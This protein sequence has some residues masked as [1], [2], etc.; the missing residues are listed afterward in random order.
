LR[1]NRGGSADRSGRP[2][3]D[4][5]RTTLSQIHLLIVHTYTPIAG[6]VAFAAP[7]GIREV[8]MM[9]AALMGGL[10]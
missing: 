8:D 7:I 1:L 3:A 9:Q 5:R 2:T 10:F 6:G 4:A